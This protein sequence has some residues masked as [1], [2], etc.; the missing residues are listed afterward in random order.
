MKSSSRKRP[1]P[2][3]PSTPSHNKQKKYQTL[4]T[5]QMLLQENTNID[6]QH[7]YDD[8]Y[9]N[10]NVP[11]NG[12][13]QK[14]KRVN[15]GDTGTHRHGDNPNPTPESIPKKRLRLTFSLP[16]TKLKGKQVQRKD[17]EQTEP[18]LTPSVVMPKEATQIIS[19]IPDKKSIQLSSTP[20]IVR[21]KKGTQ[22][23]SI[24]G[25]VQPKEDNE[26]TSQSIPGSI[27]TKKELETK[28]LL[29]SLPKVKKV[30]EFRPFRPKKGCLVAIRYKPL[31]EGNIQMKVIDSC[32]QNGHER[33]LDPWK[34]PISKSFLPYGSTSDDEIPQVSYSELWLEPILGRDDGLALVG[35]LIRCIFPKSTMQEYAAQEKGPDVKAR[36]LQG[37]VIQNMSWNTS[38]YARGLRLGGTKVRLLVD[39]SAIETIPFLRVCNQGMGDGE[40]LSS[41][42]RKRREYERIIRGKDKIVVELVLSNICDMPLL[43]LPKYEEEGFEC[44]PLRWRIRKQIPIANRGTNKKATVNRFIGDHNDT[45]L[46]QEKNWKWAV[47]NAA[48]KNAPL[49]GEVLEMRRGEIED[50]SITGGTLSMVSLRKIVIPEYTREGRLSFHHCHD[51]FDD[52]ESKLT[53]QVPIENLI[54]ISRK[55]VRNLSEKD[56]IGHDITDFMTIRQAN[57]FEKSSVCQ[58]QKITLEFNDVNNI[59][60]EKSNEMNSKGDERRQKNVDS[61]DI[62]NPSHLNMK[63]Q[64]CNNL[65]KEG[66]RMIQAPLSLLALMSKL[67]IY[68][69][70]NTDLS[71]LRF[72]LGFTPSSDHTSLSMTKELLN[73]A[74]CTAFD[75]PI[76]FMSTQPLPK[77]TPY[78]FSDSKKKS[79]KNG[80][81]A[82]TKKNSNLAVNQKKTKKAKVKKKD[83]GDNIVGEGEMGEKESKLQCARTEI[84]VHGNKPTRKTNNSANHA[85]RSLLTIRRGGRKTQKDSEKGNQSNGRAVRANQRRLLKDTTIL[86]QGVKE[87]LIGR[88][89]NLRFGKSLIHGWGVFTDEVINAGDFIVEYRG[90]LIGNAVADK[91]E[92]E[93]E[94]AKIGSDYMFRIDSGLVCDA[95]HHGCVARFINAS[96]SPNCYT[97]IIIVNGVKRIAI[98]ARREIQPGEELSYD[99]KFEPEYD[100]TKRIRKYN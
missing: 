29:T 45:D 86:G 65:V 44:V 12:S 57:R 59:F 26:T 1:L 42:E 67:R 18:P 80:S 81:I 17:R 90:I 66:S 64:S 21:L 10:V 24:P 34:P 13:E 91:R 77:A 94:T 47:S 33:I 72:P 60:V 79:F 8:E 22:S 37:I 38:E 35:K 39:S 99:Y 4:G 23:K 6:K 75:L 69:K 31:N 70:H 96:C 82:K 40:G 49:L 85:L 20:S 98:Y 5:L 50:N 83:C 41:G 14:V 88:E 25:T 54:V 19:S 53:Y 56:S 71:E 55:I 78:T 7:R 32:T 11:S 28:A 46:Q 73:M 74:S 95:T 62:S 93:Y 43:S 89:A 9:Y 61:G 52:A 68:D 36:L 58:P 84:Y 51:A 27:S 30:R 92:K 87:T 2:S 48:M 3:S 63:H 100:G 16:K 15:N 97:Q 76:S